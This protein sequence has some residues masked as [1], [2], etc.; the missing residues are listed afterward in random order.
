[1]TK[2]VYKF[3]AG[4]ADG[5]GK[6]KN[7]LGGK[8]AALASATLLGLP[9]PPG[10]TIA[11]DVCNI[12]LEEGGI[13][14][15][16]KTQAK[17]AL[18]YIE[19]IMG[20]KFGDPENPLLVSTRSGARMSMP[21]MMETVLNVGLT[22]K[23]LPGLIEIT[24]N[25][26]FVYDTYRRLIMM[27][28]DV[29]MEKAEGIQPEEG[30]GIRQQLEWIL[31]KRKRDTGAVLD[32]DLSVET[33]KELIQEFK[34]R[35][36]ETLGK[37]FPDDPYE[38]LWGAVGAVFKSWGGN[39]AVAYRR[40][41]NIPD[42]WGTACTVQSMVFGNMGEESATGVAF[43]R[44]PATGENKFYGECL[45]NAQGEDVVAGIRT[46]NPMNEESKNEQNKHLPTLEEKMPKLYQ[47]LREIKDKL[48]GYSKDMVD[49]E[50]TIEQDK[51]FLVQHRVGKRTA[52]AALN[53]AL[54]MLDEG[55]IDESTTVLRLAPSQLSQLLYPIL[56]PEAEKEKQAIAK[57]LP[58]G[59]GGA[60]GQIVFTSEDAVK[61]NNEGKKVILIREETSPEDIEGMRAANGILTARG[62]MTSHA[63]LVTR[64]WGKC[65][66]VGA[67][68]IEVDPYQKKMVI[69][70]KVY[71]EGTTI[72]LNGTLGNVYEGELPM[73]DSTKNP[74]LQEFMDLVDKYRKMGVRAN[75]ETPE[76]AIQALEF[77]AEGI[78]LF[79]TEHMFYGEGSDEPLF[80]LRKMIMSATKAERTD[81]LKEL[82]PYVKKDIK[83]T[84]EVMAGKPVTIRL[85][86]PPLHE[87]VPQSKIGQE[88][89]AHA[90]DIPLDE[91]RRRGEAL[92]ENNPMMGHRGVRLGITNPE[93]YEMQVRSILEAAAELKNE[94]KDVQ[95]EIMIPVTVGSAELKHMK[96]RVDKVYE[97]F[98]EET[99][100]EVHFMLGTM[101]EIPRAC[102][103]AGDM[104][105]TAEF[106][107]FGTN[108]LSQM[109]FGF[110][111][112]D[113][114]TFLPMY[115][116]GH[117]LRN[118]PFVSIDKRGIGQL[119]Q[120]AIERGRKTRP[121]I[122][123]GICGEHGGDARSVEFFYEIGLDYVS[124]SPYRLPIA[125]LAAAQAAIKEASTMT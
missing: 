56:D 113:I 93:V 67:S 81:A 38:Q 99:G 85:L 96:M 15:E 125:R 10:F 75:A 5:T 80:L 68:E 115:L 44:D 119:M 62:G 70:G 90:L 100:E 123:L 47:E 73:I 72:T 19:E 9:V 97:K 59:P 50:F 98:K 61:W 12:Y 48:E 63:A 86:D 109:G 45:F 40:I 105:Q 35:I 64:G 112:D 53:I 77:G 6:M 20:K 36:K 60:V 13:P 11:T 55:L 58:A 29:V 84:L 28:S 69:D 57:G 66:I 39:R 33:L 111:R 121:D 116:D 26:W 25:E 117:I 92:R 83:A 65:C 2:Y 51:L 18:K 31:S 3:G 52:T 106:F 88:R 41:E 4:K 89:L 30:K 14:E 94:G 54:D 110:S 74:R 79:R 118:D 108:D 87:F 114:E 101:I 23:T 21:G 78:G 22:T 124:C 120:I 34:V 103:R 32:T 7:E 104:A 107:S 37:E 16:V 122:K 1:M 82:S 27:Y 46:P 49:L 95:L 17:D 91:V 76:D 8:G 102:M 71:E 43:T 42:K 24:N